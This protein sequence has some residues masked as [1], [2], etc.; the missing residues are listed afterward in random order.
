MLAAAV[1]LGLGGVSTFLV[2]GK[3]APTAAAHNKA[4]PLSRL[5]FSSRPVQP[6]LLI[7]CG[8]I[9]GAMGGAAGGMVFEELGENLG[10]VIYE[11][12]K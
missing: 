4:R 2:A 7:P 3:R 12:A 9:G 8:V 5:A 6:K 10:E 11:N 1:G